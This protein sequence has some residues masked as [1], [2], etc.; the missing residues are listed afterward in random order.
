MA[1]QKI[2]E[3][4]RKEGRAV[5]TE[6]EAKEL[7]GQAGINVV[8]TRLAASKEQAV[9]LSQQLG[10]PVVLK[11]VSVDVVHKTDA[12]GVILGLKTT[13]QVGKS[14]GRDYEIGEKGFPKR[15]NRRRIRPAYGQTGRRG[16]YRNVQRCASSARADVRSRRDFC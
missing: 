16:Y 8:E 6:I 3:K 9:A 12:G 13:V 10:F 2:F 11:I 15:Q 5:L 7:L 14:L 4:A 1:G